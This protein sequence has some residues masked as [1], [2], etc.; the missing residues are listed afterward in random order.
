MEAIER[1]S[2]PK[3]RTRA[4][5]RCFALTLAL[6]RREREKS[7]AHYLLIGLVFAD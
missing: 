4:V 2:K 7:D 1:R 6:S 3:P 5:L